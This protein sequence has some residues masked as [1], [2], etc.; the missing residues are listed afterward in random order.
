MYVGREGG[1]DGAVD[2]VQSF[3]EAIHHLK[4][5]LGNDSSSGMTKAD[6]DSLINGNWNLCRSR[7]RLETSHTNIVT[8]WRSFNTIGRNDVNISLGTGTASHRFY[9]QSAGAE[10][11]VLEVA[12]AAVDNWRVFLNLRGLL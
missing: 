7:Q 11:D 4:D 6:G 12:E 9:V 10:Y 3:F 2:A 8:H 5:W 1:T